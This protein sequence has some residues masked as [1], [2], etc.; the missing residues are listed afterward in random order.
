MKN[1]KQDEFALVGDSIEVRSK[2]GNIYTI[3]LGH[4][5]CPGFGFHRECRHYQEAEEDGWIVKLKESMKT[6]SGITLSDH[7]RAMRKDA[8]RQFLVKNGIS[9]VETTIDKIEIVLTSSM[10][11]QELLDMAKSFVSHDID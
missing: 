4:C 9:F 7:A 8:I 5:T 1:R 3:T 11:P 6:F 2:S 10:R